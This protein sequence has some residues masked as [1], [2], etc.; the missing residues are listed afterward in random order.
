MKMKVLPY[1]QS[2]TENYLQMKINF[3]YWFYFYYTEL[4]Q[5]GGTLS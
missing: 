4:S 3:G 1:S 2:I 5:A